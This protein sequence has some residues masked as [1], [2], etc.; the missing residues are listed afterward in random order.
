MRFE[1][2]RLLCLIVTAAVC[3]SLCFCASGEEK[4]GGIDEAAY[5]AVSEIFGETGSKITF[6]GEFLDNAGTSASD[7]LVVALDRLGIDADYDSYL[8][9]LSVCVK[10]KYRTEGKLHPVK[11]TEW[12]RITLAVAACGGNP[13]DF[14][15]IDLIGDGVTLRDFEKQG[16]NA[17][18]WG[19]IALDSVSYDA[20]EKRDEIIAKLLSAQLSDGG[21]ALSGTM[22]DADVTAM[23]LT[24]LAAYRDREGVSAA[25][26]RAL[27]FLSENQLS[28]GGFMSYGIE[29]CESSAQVVTALCSLGISPFDDERFVKG[30]SSP[31]DAMM[32]YELENGGFSHLLSDEKM[33]GLATE[34]ALIALAAAKRYLS[35]EGGVYDFGGEA[36]KRPDFSDSDREFLRNLSGSAQASDIGTLRRILE[37]LEA[38][39]PEDYDAVKIAAE[40]AL[41]E[42]EKLLKSIEKLCADIDALNDKGVKLSDKSEISRLREA[43]GE[44]SENDK[45]LVSNYE[46]LE[47][48]EA[49]M[50]GKVRETV[51]SASL[52]AVVAASAAALVIRRR[53]RRKKED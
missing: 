45:K 49:E 42:A 14:C 30:G 38:A 21:F 22:G 9:A 34:Q 27:D 24:A 3:L 12:H 32:G 48:L 26:E 19:L 53:K 25:V 29:N 10:E 2:K 52:A 43:Y 33:N 11:A 51:V 6:G 17:Y 47:R 36:Q 50:D 35:G 41:S 20:G 5:S 15:G 46:A 31:F 37:T 23:V 1:M 18:I 40:T 7:W 39:K 28:N 16:I 8:S 13:A 4:S 44:L